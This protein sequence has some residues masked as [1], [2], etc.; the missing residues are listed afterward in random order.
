MLILRI[1]GG[2]VLLLVVLALGYIVYATN[3]T[4][5][6]V[7]RELIEN[8]QG[9][10]AGRVMMLTL[11]SGRRIPVNYYQEEGMVFAGA[12]GPWW[13]EMVGDGGRVSV[14]IRGEARHGHG[15][16]IEDDPA[17]TERVFAKLRPNAVKGF[18]IL[19][20]IKIDEASR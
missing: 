16:A 8:P 2:V 1:L 10:R 17:Y 14:L 5:P 19:I 4:N 9:E 6:R 12:D 3:V 7:E 13:K 18:G 20:E 11:P 15:R